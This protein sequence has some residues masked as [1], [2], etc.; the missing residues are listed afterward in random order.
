[1]MMCFI[2]WSWDSH[3]QPGSTADDGTVP[4]YSF[5][6]VIGGVFGSDIHSCICISVNTNDVSAH[7][8]TAVAI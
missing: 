7:T 5:L 3:S 2:I 8:E 4:C 1:M 6:L